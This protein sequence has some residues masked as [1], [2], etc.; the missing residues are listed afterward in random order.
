MKTILKI[1]ASIVMGT[2]I[3]VLIFA[4]MYGICY[5]MVQHPLV[6]LIVMGC[7]LVLF[8]GC[9]VGYWIY[10]TFFNDDGDRYEY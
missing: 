7:F 3:V 4:A 1:V 5:L 10:E 9:L 6:S 8:M 2:I